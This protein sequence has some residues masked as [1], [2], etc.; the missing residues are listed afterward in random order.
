MSHDSY[1]SYIAEAEWNARM[2]ARR[3]RLE[4]FS[5]GAR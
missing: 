5:G 3:K 1:M 4:A 2:A